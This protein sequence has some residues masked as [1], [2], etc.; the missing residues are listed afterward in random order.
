MSPRPPAKQ[1]DGS[2]RPGDPRRVGRDQLRDADDG[3]VR[4]Q[5]PSDLDLRQPNERDVSAD[6]KPVETVDP[7][8]KQGQRDLAEGRI[9][10]DQRGAAVRT[11]RRAVE[12]RS[13]TPPGKEDQE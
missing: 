8:V 7:V 6:G 2:R 13:K 10:T 1:P 9:D 4:S 11:F 5:E 3:I 12:R